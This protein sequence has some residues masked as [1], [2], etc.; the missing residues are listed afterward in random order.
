MAVG[1]VG[2]DT[3][4]ETKPADVIVEKKAEELKA[5][6]NAIAPQ[7][8]IPPV[9]APPFEPTEAE[10]ALAYVQTLAKEKGKELT[11]FDDLFKDPEKIVEVKEIDKHE[12]LYDDDDLQYLNFK[13][14]TNG[15]SR[16]EFD[17]LKKDWEAESPLDLAIALAR[18][19]SGDSK[20]SKKKVYEFLESDLNVD[21][22]DIDEISDADMIKLKRYTKSFVA[23]KKAEAQKY[24]VP[25]ERQPKE[26]EIDPEKYI[27]L[28]DGSFVLKSV[29]EESAN[30]RELQKTKFLEENKAS[31]TEIKETKFKVV[32]DDN[33]SEKTLTYSYDYSDD[34]R[35][36]M[37][38][39]T[40]DVSAY[41]GNQYK[42][43]GV[44]DKAS[45]NED[46]F[47]AN[48]KNREKVFSAIA[49]AARAE[50]IAELHKSDNNVNY[51]RN[52]LQSNGTGGKKLDISKAAG[53]TKKVGFGSEFLSKT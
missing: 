27:K 4:E 12:D 3:K 14:D 5:E 34:D 52:S 41:V 30:N 2:K 11:G 36:D 7:D 51:N 43:D 37:L 1:F 32:I 48:P 44:F 29:V 19:E 38:S 21:L 18:E 22:A 15:R 6:K 39:V 46:M 33:G 47:Y 49:N 40:N 25:I 53:N 26:N 35:N 28:D 50:L 20:M 9:D 13:K 45:F 31:V 8:N 16:K 23:E 24:L 42:K 10:K 17:T